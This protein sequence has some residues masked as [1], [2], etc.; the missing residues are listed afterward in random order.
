M[1]KEVEL[2]EIS[3]VLHGANQLTG[4]ISVKNEQRGVVKEQLPNEEKGGLSNTQMADPNNPKAILRTALSQALN[5][6]VEI[7]DMDENSVIF[8]SSPGMVW[9]AEVRREGNRY[10]VGAPTR[11]TPVTKYMSMGEESNQL[12]ED[13]TEDAMKPMG[14]KEEGMHGM[15]LRDGSVEVGKVEEPE[16]F[17]TEATALSWSM[18]LRCEGVHSHDGRF[19]PCKDRDTYMSALKMFD[20]NANINAQN[21][22]EADVSEDESVKKKNA[23]PCS[24]DT[25]VKG[26]DMPYVG[27]DD[28]EKGGGRG[29]GIS[30]S[31]QRDPMALML[32]AYNAMLPL[33]GAKKE[34]EALLGMIDLLEDYM[35]G[36][37]QQEV[38]VVMATPKSVSGYVVNVKCQG[39]Q[40]FEVMDQMRRIPVYASQTAEG[41]NL[42]FS[43]KANHDD[44]LKRVARRIS[45][46]SFEPEVSGKFQEQVDTNS[47]VK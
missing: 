29:Y 35:T 43:T 19:F 41:V 17:S 42:H 24:C 4:T 31:V 8:E 28:D 37:M 23:E 16:G 21:S 46:L 1:L 33:K 18:T 40:K 26:G 12:N 45:R 2:Y 32:M 9:R 7:M 15:L 27:Y 14:V 22:Y 3:P 39:D 13:E 6:P 36:K 10:M 44:L 25:E 38:E 47:G 30:P 20:G 34:R 11:V 5:K